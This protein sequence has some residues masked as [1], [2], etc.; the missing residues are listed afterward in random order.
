LTRLVLYNPSA[1]EDA[2]P[3]LVPHRSNE[4]S[5]Q[6]NATPYAMLACPKHE[7]RNADCSNECL[8]HRT[9]RLCPRQRTRKHCLHSHVVEHDPAQDSDMPDIMAAAH[10]VEPP[11]AK[12]L[13]DFTR[14]QERA[15]HVHD[16]ALSN[17]RVEVLRPRDAARVRELAER[18]EARERERAVEQD[19]EPGHV[20]AVEG[21]VPRQEHAADAEGG[22]DE[23]VGPPADG[24][25]VE[26]GVLGRHDAGGDE[27]ADARVVDAGEALEQRLVADGVHGVPDGATDEALA[28][29]E[30]EDGGNEDVGFGAVAEVRRGWVEVERKREHHQEAEQV[31]PDVDELVVD[32][33]HGAHTRPFPLREA[34]SLEDV[35][36]YTPRLGQVV[37]MDEA[38]FFCTG[39]G[40]GDAVFDGEFD[41]LAGAAG[42][43]ET[44]VDDVSG[45]A[46]TLVHLAQA[47]FVKLLSV[48]ANGAILEGV[49]ARLEVG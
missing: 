8:I 33:D 19:A 9:T 44:G 47:F 17:R 29:R 45:D 43:V 36:V 4:I 46:E 2:I 27:E 40:A 1:P 35:R 42:L 48:G 14:I 25:A 21:R 39:E 15:R 7:E 24:L 22:G 28:G 20:C 18:Q 23:H 12:A 38:M 10:V 30:E 16:Q 31:G 32:A 34:V 41:C 26:G 11:G 37:V 6:H 13:G 5:R 49:S 3:A